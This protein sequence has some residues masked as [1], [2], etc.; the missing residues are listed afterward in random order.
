MAVAIVHSRALSGVAAP[1]VSVEVHLAG[2]LPG[3]NIVGLAETKCARPAI[4]CAQRC[5][6]RG[7]NFPRAR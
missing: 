2:G 3:V 6:T 5:R 1:A 7:S 4:G